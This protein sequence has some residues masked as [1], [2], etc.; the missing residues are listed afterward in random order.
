MSDTTTK[1]T[2]KTNI[3]SLVEQLKVRRDFKIRGMIGEP[4]HKDRLSYISLTR[5]IQEDKDRE[6]DE[7]EIVHAVISAITPGLHLHNVLESTP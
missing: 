2:G 4:G 5:Q 6:F 7:Q 3:S 1:D